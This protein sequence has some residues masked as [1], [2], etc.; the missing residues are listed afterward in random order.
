MNTDS[1]IINL[2]ETTDCP[3]TKRKLEKMLTH[4]NRL[5]QVYTC[6]DCG[7]TYKY[8]SATRHFQSKKHNE[9]VRLGYQ[10]KPK[11]AGFR[12]KAADLDEETL[13]A[14]R[15]WYRLKYRERKLALQA[16][17]ST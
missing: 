4:V 6:A 1:K 5:E 8:F 15:E 12:G 17:H 14:K 2:I 10:Y 9:S 13:K 7:F 3:E 11:T 16:N